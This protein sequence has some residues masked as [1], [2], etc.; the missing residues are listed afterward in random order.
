M[1]LLFSSFCI[2]STVH[3]I[4]F[5]ITADGGNGADYDGGNTANA[6][7]DDANNED[8]QYTNR[9]LATTVVHVAHMFYM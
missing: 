4:F 7:R 5:N 3:D 8:D 2:Q 1:G 9:T 6:D